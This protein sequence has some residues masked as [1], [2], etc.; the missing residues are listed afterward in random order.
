[1]DPTLTELLH[2]NLEWIFVGGKGGVGKTTTSCALAT[3][4][5]TTPI[6]DATVPG[7]TRMRRVLLISTDPAH[8]LSDAFNQRFGPQ[9]TPVKGLEDCLA[10]MEVDPKNFTHGALM[11]SL[12]GTTNDASPSSLSEGA[13]AD[14]AKDTASFAR[15]GAVLKE[16]ARTMPGI[17]EISVFAEILHYVRTLSYDVLIFDTAPTG[18]T[19][20]LL[21][22]PQTLNSTFDRLMS[23]EGLAPMLEAASHL[24]GSSLGVD[25]D[26]RGDTAGC[27]QQATAAPSLSNA[28]PGEGSAAAAASSQSGCWITADEVRAKALH[29]RQVMEEVQVRFNDANR[30]SFVCVCIAEFLSVYETERLVQELMKYNIGC[31]SI[32]VNQLVLKPSSEPPCRM[33]AARQKIQARYLEQ[34][35][36]LYEDFHVVKMPLLSDEVRGVPALKTFARFLKEPYSADTHGYIDVMGPC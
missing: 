14:A 16:A 17:D 3:L 19:L 20:R 13:E 33:C 31:D 9:P 1:M 24:F 4:F 29:W 21:A 12:T 2:S 11:S 32:V 22:L 25:G 15:I 35:D 6:S 36:L 23:L 8:N 27:G 7:G 26:A 5:A 18:H 10:A 30:T 34:I 28:V